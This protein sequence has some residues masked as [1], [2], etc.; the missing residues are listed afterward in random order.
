MFSLL[1][2]FLTPTSHTVR[3]ERTSVTIFSQEVIHPCGMENSD[4]TGFSKNDKGKGK[5]DK[6]KGKSS[7]TSRK[8]IALAPADLSVQE[9][10]ICSTAEGT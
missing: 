6:G 4:G 1:A 7:S 5:S 10:M 3:R 8:R 9:N 2:F